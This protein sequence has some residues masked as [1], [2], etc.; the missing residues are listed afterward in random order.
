MKMKRM[1]KSGQQEIVGF[2]LIVIIVL[3]GGMIFLGFSIGKGT[4]S[5]QKSIEIA[6]FLEASLWKTTNCSINSG[7]VNIEELI[8]YCYNRQAC[9]DNT[10][11]CEAAKS[12]YMDLIAK[13]F[14]IGENSP[15]KAY[16]LSIYYI[17]NSTYENIL[18]LN[19]GEFKNCSS[20][21]GA[22]SSFVEN[23]FSNG[24]I[25]VEIEVCKQG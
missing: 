7:Y 1:N 11:S 6:N 15:N 14:N 22:S 23:S 16:N 21:P 18:D 3:V 24:R 20:K 13:S 25:N 9:S 19:E 12:E 4:V 2:V 10:D 8:K 5:K 17:S